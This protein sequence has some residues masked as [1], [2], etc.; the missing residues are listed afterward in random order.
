MSMIGQPTTMS[1]K[2]KM[3]GRVSNPTKSVQNIRPVVRTR[4]SQTKST[5]IEV[6]MDRHLEI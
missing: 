4:K 6:E 2:E 1:T 3:H 5:G